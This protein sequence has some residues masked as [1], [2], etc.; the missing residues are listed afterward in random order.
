MPQDT[1]HRETSGRVRCLHGLHPDQC[2]VCLG[3]VIKKRRPAHGGYNPFLA[4]ATS[5]SDA[6][7]I[8]YPPRP[9]KEV[10]TMH[11]EIDAKVCRICGMEKPLE[12]FPKN[13]GC[14]D[15]HENQCKTCKAQ[16]NRERRHKRSKP[17]P[18]RPAPATRHIIEIDV[19]EYPE[20]RD[21][22]PVAARLHIRSIER[23]ALAYIVHGL[24]QENIEG[25]EVSARP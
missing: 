6:V 9:D 18:P 19:S 20:V 17:A 2:A 7:R 1:G 22:L 10:K 3:Q 16:K 14:K 12:A 5:F 4:H 24:Q 8:L 13:P 25:C 23:Q 15:G 11:D 21:N